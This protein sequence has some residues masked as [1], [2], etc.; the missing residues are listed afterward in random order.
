MYGVNNLEAWLTRSS[1]PGQE[2]CLFVLEQGELIAESG[3][4]SLRIS[5][6][7]PDPA[8]GKRL[9]AT[10]PRHQRWYA[11]SGARHAPPA[12]AADGGRLVA[13]AAAV[14]LVRPRPPSRQGCQTASAAIPKEPAAFRAGGVRPTGYRARRRLRL[15]GS[16]RPAGTPT[17]GLQGPSTST[18]KA[19]VDLRVLA[20]SAALRSGLR[21]QVTNIL[22]MIRR[23]RGGSLPPA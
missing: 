16:D 1:A 9:G 2:S 11:D 8:S 13:P 5:E 14:V 12:R 18:L 7:K 23:P 3:D 21:I 6:K 22:G 4:A 10:C 19:G 20:L 15:T 17:V